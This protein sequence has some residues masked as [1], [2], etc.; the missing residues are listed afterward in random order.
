MSEQNPTEG[1]EL[2]E[3]VKQ[4]VVSPDDCRAALDFWTHFNIPVP[5]ALENAVSEFAK[6]PTFDNQEL[7]KLEV[8]RAI[9]NT[10]HEAFKDEMFLKIVEECGGV[11]WEMLFDKDLEEALTEDKSTEQK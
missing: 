9:A 10:D 3:A 5:T 4:V 8:C 6:A 2:A 7:V 1:T 11:T